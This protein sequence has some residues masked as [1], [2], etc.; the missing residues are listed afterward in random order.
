MS[1]RAFLGLVALGPIDPEIV[2]RL[3]TAVA[4]ILALPVRVLRPLILPEK[5][6]HIVRGQ[7]HSTQILEYL[8]SAHDSGAFRILGV[9]AVDLYIPILTFVFGEAQLN[10]TAAVIS[11]FRP[12]GDADGT[13]PPL[14]VVLNRLI[15]LSIH[16]LGHT[17]G[18]GHCREEGCLMGFSANLEKLDRKN[19]A[20]CHYC[21]VLLADFFQEHQIS[22]RL[23]RYEGTPSPNVAIP[24]AESGR[25]RR[26]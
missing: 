2:R 7:Y 20:L 17:F 6:F 13:N 1:H 15:K 8:L 10:G 21:Q 3:R 5:T 12:R 9:T 4:K 26:R 11:L 14:A 18:L 19:L 25:T 23:K 24:T 16:E 22:P